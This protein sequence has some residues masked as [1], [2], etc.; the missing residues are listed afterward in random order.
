M[1]E[2]ITNQ[3]IV[4]VKGMDYSDFHQLIERVKNANRDEVVIIGSPEV[5]FDVE[6]YHA[7]YISKGVEALAVLLKHYWS[8]HE[9]S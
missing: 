3:F 2:Q 4:L 8:E 9:Q 7:G 5:E 6:V 1:T